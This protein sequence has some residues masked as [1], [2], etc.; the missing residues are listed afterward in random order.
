MST[1]YRRQLIEFAD[2]LSEERRL[3][4]QLLFKLVEARLVLSAD[5]ARFVPQVLSE[6]EAVVG[7]LKAGESH[8]DTLASQLAIAIGEYPQ[9]LTL[10]F[11]A[12][13]APEPYRIMFED[14]RDHFQR[15]TEEIEQATLDNRRLATLAMENAAESLGVLLGE[16]VM[17]VYGSRG[18]WRETISSTGV[19]L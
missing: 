1:S 9:K 2:T 10:S 17:A 5:E 7:R 18:S 4:E 8:R 3:L 16:Q 12:S 14:H 19:E 13:W 6:V 11:L 15:L